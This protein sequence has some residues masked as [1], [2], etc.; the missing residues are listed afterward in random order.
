MQTAEDLIT[1]MRRQLHDLYQYLVDPSDSTASDLLEY[2]DL[3]AHI[4]EMFDNL[5][6]EVIFIV[7]SCT[8]CMYCR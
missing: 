1:I 5:K 2:S 3:I 4:R 7:S 8:F 6:L